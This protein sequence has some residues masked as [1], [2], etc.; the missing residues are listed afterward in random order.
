MPTRAYGRT[1]VID[2]INKATKVPDGKERT[3]LYK[4]ADAV[5]LKDVGVLPI[6]HAKTMAAYR[7]VVEGEIIHPQGHFYF[8]EVSKKAK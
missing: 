7:P 4:K 2:I 3:A 5:L 1:R 6:S 8:T